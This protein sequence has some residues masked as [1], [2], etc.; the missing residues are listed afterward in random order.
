MKDSN[1]LE[2]AGR[3]IKGGVPT[4]EVITDITEILLGGAHTEEDKNALKSKVIE[5]VEAAAKAQLKMGTIGVIEN[6]S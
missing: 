6:E 2:F 1:I 5:I 4:E 3:L